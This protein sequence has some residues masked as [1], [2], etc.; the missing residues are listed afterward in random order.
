MLCQFEAKFLLQVAKLPH[1]C[2]Y[3]E[4]NFQ[5]MKISGQKVFQSFLVNFQLIQNQLGLVFY[6]LPL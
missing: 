6:C 5:K 2:K 4:I 1:F 3:Q